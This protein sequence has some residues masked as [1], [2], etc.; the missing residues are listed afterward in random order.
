MRYL[1]EDSVP[2]TCTIKEE[3]AE[4]VGQTLGE[5]KNIDYDCEA[6]ALQDKTIA[7]VSLNTYFNMQLLKTDGTYDSVDFDDV[8]FNGNSGEESQNLAV[9]SQPVGIPGTLTGTLATISDSTLK[10]V[11]Y[12]DPRYFFDGIDSITLSILTKKDG[13]MDN[14]EYQCSPKQLEN[15]QWELDCDTSSNPLVTTVGQLHSSTGAASNK[16]FLT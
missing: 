9:Q 13:K 6:T 14:F 2:S 4:F 5:A 16:N 10:L 1:D 12:L 8:N 11:G 3:Y 7:N 15:D